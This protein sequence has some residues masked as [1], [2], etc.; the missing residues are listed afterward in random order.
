MMQE[1][2]VMNWA[3]V[4]QLLLYMVHSMAGVVVRFGLVISTVLVLNGVLETVYI[5][6]GE[7]TIVVIG[8]MLV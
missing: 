8:K 3:M 7:S 6:D 1:L 5:E 2:C 4:L